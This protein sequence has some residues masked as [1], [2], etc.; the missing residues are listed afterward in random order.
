MTHVQVIRD[1]LLATPAVTSLVTDRIYASV[2]PQGCA[3]PY[4][5]LTL[6]SAVPAHTHD[7]LPADLLEQARVQVASYGPEYA[8]IHAV[9]EAI[10]EIVGAL[11]GP[12]PAPS[13]TRDNMR[14][15]Y[16]DETSL[17]VVA[18]DYMVWL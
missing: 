6:A 13:A 10:D 17:Y 3:R 2:A 15:M 9:A 16:D 11:S 18:A 8:A 14:D 12:S 7:G 4:V 5:V 1:A